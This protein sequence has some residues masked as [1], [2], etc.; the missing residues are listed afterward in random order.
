M[1]KKEKEK[2]ATGVTLYSMQQEL[3]KQQKNL[4]SC[5]ETIEDLMKEREVVDETVKCTRAQWK[6]DIDRLNFA[7]KK[8]II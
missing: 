4:E 5:Q 8:G 3:Y 6:E 7:K 1:K 2:E